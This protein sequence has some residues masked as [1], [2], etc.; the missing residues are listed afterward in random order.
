MPTDPARLAELFDALRAAAPTERASSLDA[1]ASTEPHAA[2]ELRRLLAALVGGLAVV[3]VHL[4]P[5]RRPSID[6]AGEAID[7]GA[8][9]GVT[10]GESAT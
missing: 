10:S 9:G 4:A 1:L 3:H 6:H 7:V 5:S 2:A 8:T